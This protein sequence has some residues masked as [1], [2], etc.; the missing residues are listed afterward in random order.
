MRRKQVPRFGRCMLPFCGWAC[1]SHE[2]TAFNSVP[3]VPRS[4]PPGRVNHSH[5]HACAHTRTSGSSKTELGSSSSNSD[6]S[7]WLIESL[8]DEEPIT[9][10]D[11]SSAGEG[12]RLPPSGLSIASFTILPSSSK[13]AHDDSVD[14]LFYPIYLLLGRNGWGTGVHPTTRLCLEFIEK[15]VNEGDTL[16]DYG[17]GS[18]I[19]SVGALHVGA[20]R[21][22][23]VDIEAE[24]LVTAER[25]LELN[26]FSERASFL[27]TRE[28]L[29]FEICPPFGVDICVANILIGQLVR[30]SMVAA[31]LSNLKDGGLIC[32]SGIRPDEVDSLKEAYENI[33]WLEDQYAELTATETTNCIESYGFDVG[34]WARL[35]GRKKSSSGFIERM[36]ELAIQ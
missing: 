26:E 24:A 25:N 35:V 12:D 9:R 3:L 6:L 14:G 13:Q 10:E 34:N 30:P 23:G 19:L 36:S 4:M 33:E 11:S 7:S 20:S 17:C 27:H 5:A 2:S 8:E 22:I 18:G 32:L 15:N 31:L 1:H 16:L 21:V 28:V 29:P